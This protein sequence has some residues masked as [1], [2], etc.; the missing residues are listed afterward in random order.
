MGRSREYRNFLVKVWGQRGQYTTELQ[1]A[2]RWHGGELAI[3]PI[4]KEKAQ[5]LTDRECAWSI[6]GV[7]TDYVPSG[8]HML[9]IVDGWVYDIK[10]NR[11]QPATV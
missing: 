1:V 2:A 7:I 3:D 10:G 5:E 6:I 11:I 4:H 8:M 9:P